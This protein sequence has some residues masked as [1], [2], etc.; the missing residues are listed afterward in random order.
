MPRRGGLCAGA[1]PLLVPLSASHE[2]Q[3]VEGRQRL[4]RMRAAAGCCL[5]W[6]VCWPGRPQTRCGRSCAYSSHSAT[7]AEPSAEQERS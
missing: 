6:Q 7:A 1:A 4:S 3:S 5:D 2:S